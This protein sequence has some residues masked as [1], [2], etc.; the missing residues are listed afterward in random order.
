VTSLVYGCQGLQECDNGAAFDLLWGLE[1]L[2]RVSGCHEASTVMSLVYGRQGLQECDNGAAF[3]VVAGR[4]LRGLRQC[5]AIVMP[6]VQSR[7]HRWHERLLFLWSHRKVV[8]DFHISRVA[9]VPGYETREVTTLDPP[10]R[11]PGDCP[12]FPQTAH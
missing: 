12:P 7:S 8:I 10:N 6:H 2:R 5:L 9:E 1:R 11:E 4:M 3:D